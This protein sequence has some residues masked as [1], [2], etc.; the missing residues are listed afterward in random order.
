MRSC[1]T[2][3]CANLMKAR[4]SSCHGGS[5][6]RS[7]PLGT[8]SY[9]LC[10]GL[11]QFLN[12]LPGSSS[13]PRCSLGLLWA[14]STGAA[15]GLEKGLTLCSRLHLQTLGRTPHS[16]APAAPSFSP[17]CFVLGTLRAHSGVAGSVG[18]LGGTNMVIVATVATS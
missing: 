10:F 16:P 6:P 11:G 1:S 7:Q 5:L 14:G 12:S 8:P 3:S 4:S 17:Q 13:I 18:S 15:C 2:S 9:I